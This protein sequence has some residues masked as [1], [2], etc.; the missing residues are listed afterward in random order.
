MLQIFVMYLGEIDKNNYKTGIKISE[1]KLQEI[2]MVRNSFH[3]EW[4][5][6]VFPQ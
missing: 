4:N 5:Y 6:T 2:N 3:G 1:K